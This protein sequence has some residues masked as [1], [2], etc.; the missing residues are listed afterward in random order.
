VLALI[1]AVDRHPEES[2][3]TLRRWLGADAAEEART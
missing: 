3:Y 1:E 2:L